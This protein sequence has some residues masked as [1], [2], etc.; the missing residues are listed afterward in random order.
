MKKRFY[1]LIALII[2]IN[3]VFGT[4]GC[5]EPDVIP[6]EVTELT[7]TANN[8]IVI[9][10]W[11]NPNDE[12]FY[13]V[14]IV[15]SPAEGTLANPVMLGKE[16]TSL[17]VSG[18]KNETEYTF[19]L[20][21]FD[22]SLKLSAGTTVSVKVLDTAD[23]IAPSEVKNFTVIAAA[24]NSVLSWENPIDTDFVGVQVS[25]SP[26]EGTLTILAKK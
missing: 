6:S 25:M 15:M 1:W 11:K 17:N 10:S 2:A 16:V 23:Y 4:F 24:G 19:T 20:K 21:T 5:K 9:L 22:A 8:G 18:L 12:D 14:Q 26:T 3:F 7:A 13:G